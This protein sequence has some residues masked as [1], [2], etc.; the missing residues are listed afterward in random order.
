M[1]APIGQVFTQIEQLLHRSLVTTAL[2][3]TMRIASWGHTEM[4]PPHARHISFRTNALGFAIGFSS[5]DTG[6]DEMCD[7]NRLRDDTTYSGNLY[8]FFCLF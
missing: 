3:V 4:H 8:Y 6:C 1:I 5:C 7:T 2:L